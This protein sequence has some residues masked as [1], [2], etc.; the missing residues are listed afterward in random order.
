MSA[1]SIISALDPEKYEVTA[2]G[3]TKS[4]QWIKRPIPDEAEA[5]D[6]PVDPTAAVSIKPDPT[7][8]Q[9][10][11]V[12]FPVLH[13]TYG[14]DGTI[15]GL[16]ELAGIPYVGAG[17]TASAVSMD[18]AVMRALFAQAGLPV[19]PWEVVT[20]HQFDQEQEAVYDR[21]KSRLTFPVFVKPANLGS[22]VGITKVKGEAGLEEA[23]LTAFA[24]DRKV[25][26]EQGVENAREI[27]CSVLGN[28]DPEAAAVLGEIVPANEF[29]DY[30]AKYH[31]E[32]SK[33]IIPAEVTAEE[34]EIIRDLAVRAYKA[35]DC[36]GMAR[37]DFFL[38]RDGQVIINEINT[39][40]GFTRISMY[41]KL[42]EASGL[43]Y[44]QLVDRLI[45]LALS[46][47]AQRQKLRTSL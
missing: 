43:P 5:L 13:G 36:A 23:L 46:R 37:V 29:Y 17:V 11:D 3:I 27:E 25:V 7:L 40:P 33:L 16:L 41:P 12:I 6:F 24:Y 32:Q 28:E 9:G 45:F 35:V 30:Q 39:I 26:V 22:S 1:R 42:W 47:H 15:Q 34:A 14:E 10:F 18:K 19:V 38:T 2:I 4:G 31:S 8:W 20:R 21:I 44:R